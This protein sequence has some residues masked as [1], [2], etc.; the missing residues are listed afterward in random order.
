MRT[1]E[2]GE[3]VDVG[4]LFRKGAPA[5]PRWFRWS[6]R[7]YDVEKVESFWR[8]RRGE[9]PL[10]FFA[11]SSAGNVYELCCD[12]KTL[13]WSLEKVHSKG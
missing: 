3:A 4:V 1:E 8:G 12:Q 7:K 2:V 10:L 5:A 13:A 11:V 9:A 6:G